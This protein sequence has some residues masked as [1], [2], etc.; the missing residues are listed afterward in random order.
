MSRPPRLEDARHNNR[1]RLDSLGLEQMIQHSAHYIR[2]AEGR[3]YDCDI[4]P[5]PIANTCT[6][7]TESWA[8]A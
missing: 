5:W 8:L 4:G 3:D 7:V 6:K 1:R 2:A